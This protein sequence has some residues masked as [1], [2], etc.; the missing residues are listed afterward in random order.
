MWLGQLDSPT[1]ASHM[2]IFECTHCLD[3]KHDVGGYLLIMY[4][5][6]V[7]KMWFIWSYQSIFNS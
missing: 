7:G 6:P 2:L 5:G 4:M 1:C 3:D